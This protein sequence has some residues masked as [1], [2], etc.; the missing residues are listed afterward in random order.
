[1]KKIILIGL[2]VCVAVFAYASAQIYT[3]EKI[4]SFNMNTIDLNPTFVGWYKHLD[5]GYKFTN[6]IGLK[7]VDNNKYQVVTR[8]LKT[9]IPYKVITDCEI[10]YSHAECINYAKMMLN[11]KEKT[12]TENQYRNFLKNYQTKQPI[13]K[14]V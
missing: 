10:L 9:R 7:K 12:L 13:E 3:Q 11:I 6:V 5:Y 4:D 14:M 8:T 2:L 1:M